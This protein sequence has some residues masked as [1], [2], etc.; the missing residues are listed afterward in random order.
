V[1]D[2]ASAMVKTT[3]LLKTSYFQHCS[4]HALHLL[5]MKDAMN[6]I[7]DLKELIRRCND[8]VTKLHFK[9]DI[10][11]EEMERL[12]NAKVVHDIIARVEAAFE[13]LE[14]EQ[15]I[16]LEDPEADEDGVNELSQ[17]QTQTASG[18]GAP[19]HLKHYRRLRQ[20]VITRWNSVLQMRSSLLSLREEVN[21]ALKRT[22]H[23]GLCIRATEWNIISQLCTLLETFESLTDVA[24]GNFV[25]LSFVP[26]IRAKVKSACEVS[27]SDCDEIQQFK[28]K[29]LAIVDKRFPMT[30]AVKLATLLDPASKNKYIE[31]TRSGTFCCLQWLHSLQAP[32]HNS[33]QQKKLIV[34]PRLQQ[35]NV[36]D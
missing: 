25:G 14:F 35:L 15:N 17:E 5:V 27:T 4:S 11:Q 20:E 23:Y 2:G 29:I 33:L 22:G 26:L 24:S 30:D 21:E 3:M 19:T 12:L 8:V 32:A 7:P 18:T 13:V 31:M 16:P 36:R 9:A 34:L 28:L 10:V 6:R 1:T